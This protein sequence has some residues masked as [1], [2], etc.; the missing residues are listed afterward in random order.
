MRS[1]SSNNDRGCDVVVVNWN[2]GGRLAELLADLAVQ[3]GVAPAVV[4]VDNDSRDDSLALARA[5]GTLFAELQTG[6]N[7]GYAGGNNA[8]LKQLPLDRPLLIANPDVRFARPDALARLLDALDAD[9]SLGCV[10]PVIRVDGR[11]EYLGSEAQLDQARAVHVRTHVEAWPAG[12]PAVLEPEW[13]DG[14]CLLFRPEVLRAVGFL[15]ERFFLFH[16]EVDWCLRAR[17]LGFRLGLV[18]ASEIGHARSSSFGSS[19]KGSYYHWRNLYL[20]CSLHSASPLR[21][22]LA[23]LRQLA[24][25]CVQ[26]HHLRGGLTLEALR[27][28]RDAL[29]GEFGAGPEDRAAAATRAAT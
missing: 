28:A 8:A 5:G 18:Q 10:A 13:L 6:A 29:R 27:G 20:L 16:E 12:A 1:A 23:W 22:R 24:Q 19:R 7:L 15:D 4:V 26:R 25:F 21:W 2:S 11:I 17:R 9:E 3:E 14:A